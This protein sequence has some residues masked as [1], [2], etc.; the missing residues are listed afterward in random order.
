MKHVYY[1]TSNEAKFTDAKNFLSATNHGLT[2]EQLP[3]DIPE[4]QSDNHDDIL[5]QKVE[6][7]RKSTNLPFIVDDASFYTERYPTFPGAYAKYLNL[8]LGIEGW[9]RLFEEGDKIRAVAR[10]A[11]YDFGEIQYFDGEI[12]GTLHFDEEQNDHLFSLN[13][14]IIVENGLVLAD[15]LADP[16]FLNHRRK[17]L[18][19]LANSLSKTN[20][21]SDKKRLKLVSAGAAVL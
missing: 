21:E 16:I 11:L 4:I 3:I 19:A 20:D 12:E 2:V 14:H 8:S 5:K 10:I 17:A 6:F 18:V 7:V 1:A 13:D 15:A 9:K